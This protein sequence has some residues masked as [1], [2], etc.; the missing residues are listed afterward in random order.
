M[1][2]TEKYTKGF[3]HY[4]YL[5]RCPGLRNRC[6]FGL[7]NLLAGSFA[8]ATELEL[9]RFRTLPFRE[10]V[11]HLIT[12]VNNGL[13]AAYITVFD[14]RRDKRR[15]FIPCLFFALVYL[16]IASNIVTLATLSPWSNSVCTYT[17]INKNSAQTLLYIFQ[18]VPMNC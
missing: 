13:L 3:E 11:W 14:L 6:T 5:C 9:N 16:S 15:C 7:A 4:S 12:Q 18:F 17:C 10:L 8:P 1:E 2:Q